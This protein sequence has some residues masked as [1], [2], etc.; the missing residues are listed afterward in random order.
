VTGR[1][2][3]RFFIEADTIE[4]QEAAENED[5]PALDISSG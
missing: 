3:S 2:D 5:Y 4:V 1:L